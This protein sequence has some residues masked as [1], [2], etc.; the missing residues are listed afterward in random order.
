V[1]I[2]SIDDAVTLCENLVYFCLVIPEFM[3]LNCVQKASIGTRISLTA[4]AR[5]VALLGTAAIRSKFVFGFGHN[6]C[7]CRLIF[8]IFFT[9]RFSR[10]LSLSM[11]VC[12]C[13]GLYVSVCLFVHLLK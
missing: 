3:T 1:Y 7:K 10:K 11:C 9:D 4:F 12:V 13:L 8:K 5:G 2:N 6:F